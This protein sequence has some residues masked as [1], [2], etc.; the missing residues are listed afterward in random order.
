MWL[1]HQV[2]FA[3]LEHRD[4]ACFAIYIACEIQTYGIHQEILWNMGPQKSQS[5]LYT[6]LPFETTTAKQF[7]DTCPIYG[8]RWCSQIWILSW[9]RSWSN[10]HAGI[11][12]K[13]GYLCM[14]SV[15]KSLISS[16]SQ[17]LILLISPILP[18]QPFY[19]YIY[20]QFPSS[21]FV[22]RCLGALPWW[23]CHFLVSKARIFQKNKKGFWEMLSKSNCK[24]IMLQRL[25]FDE[26]SV[27]LRSIKTIWSHILS[28][29]S[30][31]KFAQ[32]QLSFQAAYAALASCWRCHLNP[33][34]HTWQVHLSLIIVRVPCMC[35]Y[36]HVCMTLYF[37]FGSL[38]AAT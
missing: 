6:N 22:W 29:T 25:P 28:K 15:K 32:S 10:V 31:S 16:N 18:S 17:D 21:P 19:I 38:L 24:H 33:T 2:A 13:S 35:I 36:V 27:S 12:G 9:R 7:L 5:T 23:P 8:L 3:D 37:Y 26:S 20:I 14:C 34:M 1:P 11:K 30:F 4:F